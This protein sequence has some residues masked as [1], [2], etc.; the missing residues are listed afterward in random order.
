MKL[1][2]ESIDGVLAARL[3]LHRAE[4]EPRPYDAARDGDVAGTFESSLSRLTLTTDGGE[5]RM[6]FALQPA[7][8][9]EMGGEA[10]A[11]EPSTVG[12]LP[13][14]R[15]EYVLRDGTFEGLM[16]SFARNPDGAVTE[17]DLGGR[18]HRRA[19]A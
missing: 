16:G 19:E 8:L 13:G 3:G 15:G 18:W 4:P 1:T 2:R 14:G 6:R 5:V 9:A 12:L 17:V 7:A 11:F 10:P